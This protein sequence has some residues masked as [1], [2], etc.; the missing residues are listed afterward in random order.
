MA[1]SLRSKIKKRFRT[2]KRKHIEIVKGLQDKQD[3]NNN[4]Q[5]TIR[6]FNYRPIEKKNAFKYPKD[7]NSGFPQY[8]K[9]TLVDFRSSSIP[10]AGTEFSGAYRKKIKPEEIKP[11]E[12]D[13]EIEE[14]IEEKEGNNEGNM[15]DFEDIEENVDID[16]DFAKIKISGKKKIKK[17]KEEKD[18]I[19]LKSKEVQKQKQKKKSQR[20]CKK[21]RKTMK[22]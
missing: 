17:S 20:S 19:L 18:I 5:A 22:F 8:K 10:F 12:L 1:K 11:E 2:L 7:P 4:L 14:V 21:S 6:G 9:Q 13:I 16:Q 15:D 3:L